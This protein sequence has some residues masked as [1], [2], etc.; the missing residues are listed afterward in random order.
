M[1]T[2]HLTSGHRSLRRATR[3]LGTGLYRV[4]VS[5]LIVEL[6][7]ILL[8][9]L[10]KDQRFASVVFVSVATVALGL[11]VGTVRYTNGR[12]LIMLGRSLVLGGFGVLIVVVAGATP[13]G[14]SPVAAAFLG[15]GSLFLGLL[16]GQSR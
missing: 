10:P 5:A 4:L 9:V 2:P 8:G 11:W 6:V 14:N 12:R 1:T 16:A 7:G 3:M 13:A 15:C